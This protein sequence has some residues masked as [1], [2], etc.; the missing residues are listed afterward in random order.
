MGWSFSIDRG[1]TFTDLVGRAPG[2]ELV[3]RKVLSQQPQLAGD[4]AVAA[5]REL[6]GLPSGQPLPA[7]A[8]SEVRIGT[9][10]AT[11]ALLED[12][13]APTL[14]LISSGF[15]D[16]AWI[17]D[18]H[19]PDLFALHIERPAPRYRRVLEVEGR[20][21]ADGTELTPLRL[22]AA[23]EQA[24]NDVRR[25][26]ISSCAVALL[27]SARHPGH[28]LQ[29]AEWL[30]PFG[31]GPVVLSHQV[32]QR[33]RLVPR[34]QTAVVEATVAPAL[35]A[36]LDQ[37]RCELGAHC[38]LRVMQSSGGL[39]A[40]ELL[41]AKDTILSGPAG[42]MVAA[43]RL[44]AG[45]TP[46]VGFDMGGT[47]T[48]V[49]HVEAGGPPPGW[50]RRQET[51]IAGLSLQAEM[52][53]IHTVAAGGGSVL[54]FD[55]QR[56]QVGP[57][58]A[59]ADPGPACYRRGGPLTITDANLLLGRL[60]PE[61]FPA[62]FGPGRDQGPDAAVVQRGFQQLAELV[63]QAS[64]V[65]TTAED[66]AEGGLAV[67]IERMA[68]AIRRIS[69][70]RG[71]DVRGATLI[72]FGGAGGQHACA[73]AERLGMARV[74]LHPLAGVF[75]AYGIGLADQRLLLQELVRLRLD[76]ALVEQLQQQSRALLKRGQRALAAEARA[77]V[78]VGVRL[79]ANERTLTLPLQDARL[80]RQQFELDHER[81]FGHR[82]E[83]AELVVEWLVVE[84]VAP[85]QSVAAVAD[86]A[87]APAPAVAAPVAAEIGSATP[88]D[89][90]SLAVEERM[91]QL[92]CGGAWRSVPL[93]RRDAL[94]PGEWLEGPALV[95]ET[96]GTI[97]LAPGWLAECRP[98]GC[99][100][101][102][103]GQQADR[104][105]QLGAAV[106][107]V[108]LELF[109][110]R[111][112]AI[113]EQM[114]VRL[115]QSARSVNIRERLDF[116]CALFDC[117]GQLVANAPHIPVH[118]GSMGASVE[119][120]LSAVRRGERP[121]LKPGD[122]IVSNDPANGGT[123][124]PDLTVITPVFLPSHA[125]FVASRGHHADVGG[126]TPG[127]MP[128]FSRC[129]ADEGLLLDN[130]P[131]LRD[132]VLLT[133][134]WQRRLAS[135]PHPVRNPEQL[136]ADLQ[137]QVAANQLGAQLLVDLARREGLQRLTAFMGHV[138]DNGAEA[139]RRVIDRLEPGA[140]SLPLDGG[141]RIQ[142]AVR[143]DRPARRAVIDFTGTSPQDSGNRNAPLAITRAVVLYV[144]RC[145]VGE[146][147]PL[148]AGCF[149]PLELVVPPGC[150]LHPSPTAAVVAG[151]VET[152]Q[153]IAN[154]L[155]AALGA[156]A[157]AQGTMNNLSFGNQ[158]YQYYETICGGCGAGR[159]LDGQGFAG[160]S[161]V[162]SHMTNSRLTDPE[163]LE[164]RFPVRLEA[165]GLRRGSGGVGRWR[166]GDGVTR[167]IR[168]LEPMTAAILSSSR[169]VAPFGLAGGGAGALGRNRLIRADG[170]ELELGGSVQLELAAG[171]A[172][173][174]ETP[175]GGGYGDP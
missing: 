23:L 45:S 85:G 60:Q 154:A 156:M 74:L 25:D 66:L 162:Q 43:V 119:S 10:V 84:V 39:V 98:D 147:V 1:G 111:F 49:F 110:H 2:G 38:R 168:F 51:E 136:L 160:A 135:G 41:K 55:G 142:V 42:G 86:A 20:L 50:D 108:S 175:G 27:H 77:E 114:G 21:A 140:F 96:T 52:L 121:P 132:G 7:G 32:G 63:G 130:V 11:N 169:E 174:I 57:S 80:L 37:L 56:L 82:P 94:T 4:P 139:V 91:I 6:L 100:L 125:G 75:S 146:A 118:L 65:P 30:R 164:E 16:A 71:H 78:S 152:S 158:R 161:A 79:G 165:F 159:G 26:G 47:S 163:I 128:P 151:N 68:E 105:A 12:R 53:P 14:L 171:E 8:V 35:V 58:S 19:R 88:L 83:A 157:A 138:Q 92:H 70:Q 33:P 101:L 29:L 172:L 109:N 97:W 54:H 107:P 112:S 36:Y 133:A 73:L 153:A 102:S 67:A 62:V 143:I 28:E 131:L 122:A 48:D 117:Q 90:P 129:L 124:L 145:M 40:P 155:F 22:D 24:L 81:R 5:M 72:C 127:S 59:G 95:V 144:F 150:L 31:F 93:H 18:Q 170:S 69:I 15:A 123:H 17:G 120:L 141:L 166:G 167:R 113:A 103:H 137:A 44:A 61:A 3:V 34:A 148:N 116:S 173:V 134:D 76:Q 89:R 126:I 104:P 87:A 106:D 13:G 99:L 149:R 115:Q 64:G 46:I 9:T